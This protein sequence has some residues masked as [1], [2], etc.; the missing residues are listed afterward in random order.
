M[1]TLAN[2]PLRAS[3]ADRAH[4]AKPLRPAVYV[5]G[6][7]EREWLIA[8]MAE[9]LPYATAEECREAATA[10]IDALFAAGANL[11]VGSRECDDC[12]A[13]VSAHLFSGGGCWHC[14][15]RDMAGDE[16]WGVE[17]DR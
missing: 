2:E 14:R 8:E 17:S 13:E 11:S 12:G 6:S 10:A 9:H 3:L 15:Q 4:Y 5:E 16:A 7:P 1:T